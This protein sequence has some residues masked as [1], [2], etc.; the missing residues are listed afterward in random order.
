MPAR[1][2]IAVAL[3]VVMEQAYRRLRQHRV[4]HVSTGPQRL[5]DWNRNAGGI[6]AF[7]FADPD[8]HAIQVIER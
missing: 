7:Y 2:R 5:P 3:L 4:Q 1:V 8:G 6:E